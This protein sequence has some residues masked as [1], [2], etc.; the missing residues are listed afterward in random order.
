MTALIAY[1]L[2]TYK[3]MTRRYPAAMTV[4]YFGIVTIITLI[5]TR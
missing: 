2:R 4:W 5:A 3:V 1:Q